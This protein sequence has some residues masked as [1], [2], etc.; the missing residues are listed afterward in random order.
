MRLFIGLP[1]SREAVLNTAA[2]A[3]NASALIPGRYVLPDNYHLTLAFLGDTPSDRIGDV[4]ELLD[5]VAAQF[6]APRL[7]LGR[8]SHFS[9]RENA[10]LIRTAQSPD[11]LLS[12]H[13]S[14]LCALRM[15]G[16]PFTDGPFTPHVT[17][18]RHADCSVEANVPATPDAAFTAPH[19]LL[20]LSARDSA[21]I[22]R[23]T[24]LH[25]A[26]FRNLP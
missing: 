17:L 15:R 20:Y 13:E 11:D 26:A 8:L 4:K 24:P 21:N 1:L 10:I 5:D 16:L 9:R 3:A 19:A 25:R 2:L 18:A 6:S 12:M 23:Y 14:L 7:T 22:L